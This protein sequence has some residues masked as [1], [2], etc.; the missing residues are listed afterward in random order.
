MKDSTPIGSAS[1]N[2][3]ETIPEVTAGKYLTGHLDELR[4]SS[5]PR[6]AAWINTTFQNINDPESFA[7]FGS[8]VGVLSTWTY[9]K[10]I[11]FNSSMIESDLTNFP[12]LVHN[13]SDT[14]LKDNALSNGNDIIFLQTS[15]DWTTSTWRDKLDHEI[16]EYNTTTGELWAWVRIP[17][18]SS[19]T[20]TEIYMYY[21]NTL[22]TYNRESPA[23][24]WNHNFKGVWHMID[25]TSSTIDE[26]TENT[27]HGSKIA[28]DEPNQIIGNISKAQ[29][30]DGSNDYINCSNDNSLVFYN[31]TGSDDPMTIEVWISFN[32]VTSNDIL[33]KYNLTSG[34]VKREYIL[35][36][37]AV[38]KLQFF[39]YDESE[40]E[41]NY[42][43]LWSI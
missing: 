15:Y 20:D 7:T 40:G 12:V 13:D 41:P 9:R 38:D 34:D 22:C 32:D 29:D 21:N 35:Q 28:A 17:T 19:S 33:A 42:W 23:D 24:V 18:L 8:A 3:P 30:F 43:N 31:K 39:H 4:I 37:T 11:T 5:T 6:S 2:Y 26:S 1:I 36:T 16:E 25:N 10:K 27:N 14:D